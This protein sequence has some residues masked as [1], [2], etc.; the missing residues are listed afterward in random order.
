MTA[1]KDTEAVYIRAAA[2]LHLGFLDMNGGLGRRFGSIG[3]C[4]SD[5]STQLT[6]KRSAD[7]VVRGSVSQHSKE[8]AYAGLDALGISG[9]VDIT[10]HN[11]IPR[12]IGL[13]SG[14]QLAL[15]V[16]VAIAR[17][18]GM[19]ISV[20]NIA[21]LMGRGKR[22]GIGVGVFQSGGFI[23]DGGS[24]ESAQ[25][26]PVIYHGPFPKEWRIILVFDNS[27][28][29]VSG[30]LE[31]RIFDKLPPMSNR[32]SGE[33]CRLLLMQILPSLLEKDCAMFGAGVTATQ[34]LMGEYFSTAQNSYYSS[35]QVSEVMRWLLAHD[36]AGVGQSSW[37]PTGFAIYSNDADARAAL[38][39]ARENWQAEEK[40]D[41]QLCMARNKMAD[42][43]VDA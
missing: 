31:E 1:N 16:G 28:R 17:L 36:A 11:E 14:T 23:V 5:I 40:L 33:I 27:M 37:G 35:R 25:I 26:P 7:V 32:I 4:L 22:S 15:A 8:Y 19:R 30:S 41:F 3:L 29:G 39:A 13:G 24:S 34:E 18:H 20:A 42:I 9:G 38:K 21:A 43:I 10:I 12:H 6:A 2:R